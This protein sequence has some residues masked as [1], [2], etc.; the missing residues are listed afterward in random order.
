MLAE[1]EEGE[2]TTSNELGR[3]GH[4]YVHTSLHLRLHL[5]WAALQQRTHAPLTCFFMSN[6]QWHVFRSAGVIF[7]QNNNV[8]KF[9]NFRSLTTLTWQPDVMFLGAQAFEL[10]FAG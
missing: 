5:M 8:T 4:L 9:I 2:R 7:T 3:R 1:G 10:F 6:H